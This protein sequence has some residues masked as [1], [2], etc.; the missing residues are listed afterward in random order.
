M[1]LWGVALASTVAPDG[2]VVYNALFRGFFNHSTLWT[3]SMFV[4]LGLGLVWLTLHI[5]RRCPFLKVMVGLMTVGGF[6]HLALDVIAHGTPLLYP[7]SM[8]MFGIASARVIQ[9]GIW[10]YLTDPIFLLE[11]LLFGIA[12][13]HWICRQN[14]PRRFKRWMIVV[15]IGGLSLFSIIFA[16]ILPNLQKAIVPLMPLQ[17]VFWERGGS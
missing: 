1:L 5:I 9:G 15:I 4:Y 11:S 6:S 13:V 8:A 10:A 17:T 3:H 7:V 12:G 14:A 16:L 2:D